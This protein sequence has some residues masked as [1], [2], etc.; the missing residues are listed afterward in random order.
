M[1][2]F[3]SFTIPEYIVYFYRSKFAA[4]ILNQS[5][6]CTSLP[7]T[8]SLYKPSPFFSRSFKSW[9][10]L[11]SSIFFLSFLFSHRAVSGRVLHFWNHHRNPPPT[12]RNDW[13]ISCK[14][15]PP[16]ITITTKPIHLAKRHF[17]AGSRE[18]KRR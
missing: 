4:G 6:L 10:S 17:S 1:I 3:F 2:G 11:F 13:I 14:V 7:L 8:H 18:D 12:G 5:H 16:P 9:F 15:D